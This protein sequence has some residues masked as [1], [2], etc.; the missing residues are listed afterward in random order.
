[1]TDETTAVAP[2]R[3]RAPAKVRGIYEK[4]K[5]S[6]VWW[7]RCA[8]C[9]GRERREKAGTRGMAIALLDKR[10][11]E[12]RQGIKLPETLRHKTVTV[13]D[14]VEAAVA[15]G[16]Q[17]H[18]SL[19]GD[20]HRSKLLLALFGGM[21]ADA[22]T[23]EILERK[24]AA[25]A[26]EREWRPGTFNRHK[27][28]LSLAYRLAIANGKAKSNPGRLVRQRHED[29][30]RVRWLSAEE[31]SRLVTV[32]ERHYPAELAA[33]MLSLHTGMRRSE[34]YGLT[35]DCVDLERRQLTIPRSK[36]GGIRYVELDDTAMAAL[37]ALRGRSDGAGKVMVAGISGHGKLK[38][39]ALKTPKQWFAAACRK[40]GLADYTWHANRHTFASRL[41]MAGVGLADVKD[42]MGH[43]SFAMTLRYAHLAPQHKLAA[44][45]KL[46]G[47]GREAALA[48]VQSGTTTGTGPSEASGPLAAKAA[49]VTVQ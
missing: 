25:A 41:V 47:W 9:T 1:M 24:L 38:G 16:R 34:Q 23:P 4:V 27:A 26:A 45:R 14:L 7:V 46:D 11:M 22:L 19:G 17:H 39:E 31:E 12:R 42:L 21:A 5:G 40:A 18:R 2:K 43:K 36:H 49:Q 20:N 6:G 30:A 29:N 28:F 35:W 3:R 13:A 48:G 44:V 33:F 37:L 8:D 32:L 15:Y 10:R